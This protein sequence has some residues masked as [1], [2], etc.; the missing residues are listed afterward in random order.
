MCFRHFD[1]R[2]KHRTTKDKPYL[3]FVENG[4][5][6][7]L[8]KVYNTRS[9]IPAQFSHIKVPVLNAGKQSQVLPGTELGILQEAEAVEEIKEFP[10]MDA[11][12]PKKNLVPRKTKS[13]IRWWITFRT[14]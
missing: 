4:E 10:T 1:V 14:N 2:V 13:S 5:V 8:N 9:L 7:W 3:G 12:I 6:P 11:Q